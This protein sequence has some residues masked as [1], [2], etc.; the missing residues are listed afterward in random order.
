MDDVEGWIK[1][2]REKLSAHQNSKHN[3]L[4]IHVSD[5]SRLK[6]LIADFRIFILDILRLYHCLL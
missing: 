6:L 1:E 5:F 3:Q 4:L 2:E